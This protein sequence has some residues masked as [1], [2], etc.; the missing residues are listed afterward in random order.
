MPRDGRRHHCR[1]TEAHPYGLVDRG[2]STVA[3]LGQGDL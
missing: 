3:V 1:A 2:D